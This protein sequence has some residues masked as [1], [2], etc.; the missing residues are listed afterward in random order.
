MDIINLIY[1]ETLSLTNSDSQKLI[2]FFKIP[3]ARLVQLIFIILK[4]GLFEKGVPRKNRIF[5]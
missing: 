1:I 2:E 4:I 5:K 3:S